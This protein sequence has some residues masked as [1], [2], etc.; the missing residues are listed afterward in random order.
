[1][2]RVIWSFLILSSPLLLAGA[3][4]FQA[5]VEQTQTYLSQGASQKAQ[6]QAQAAIRLAQS[7]EQTAMAWGLLGNSYL[8]QDAP[9]SAIEAYEKSDQIHASPQAAI[10]LA[11][12]YAKLAQSRAQTL[13]LI[14][15]SPQSQ[16]V[17]M[18]SRSSRALSDVVKKQKRRLQIQQ[19]AAKEQATRYT[20]RSLDAAT[21][22]NRIQAQLIALDQ[23]LII[24]RQA[25]QIFADL[26]SLPSSQFRLQQQIQ[27]S[28]YLPQQQISILE[29][30]I[31]QAKI[32]DAPNLQAQAQLNLAQAHRGRENHE[33]ALA[34]VNQAQLLAQ[35]EMDLNLLYQG[36]RLAAQLYRQT[37]QRDGSAG[38]RSEH[39]ALSSYQQA[40]QTLEQLEGKVAGEEIF[41]R[42]YLKLLLAS[43]HSQQL[44]RA[45][46]I[47]GNL[48]IA[49]L[50][51]YLG[52]PCP[53]LQPESPEQPKNQATVTTITFPKQTYLILQL[54]TGELRSYSVSVT[55]ATLERALKTYQ[56]QIYN[57][58]GTKHRQTG[59]Q[60]YEWLIAPI[61]PELSEHEI[62]T[63]IFNH[64]NFLRNI[65]MTALYDGENYLVEDYAISNTLGLDRIE[66]SSKTLTPLI[67]GIS[68]PRNGGSRLP[69]VK[70]ET[71]QIQI[72]MGG[73]QLLDN[74]FT[75]EQFKKQLQDKEY[76]ALHI[77]SHGIFGGTI[78]TSY[79]LTYNRPLPMTEFYRLLS[80]RPPLRLLVLSACETATGNRRS[81]L[82][83]AGIGVQT[84]AK[85]V[86]GTLW[87]LPDNK[88]T[89]ELMTG[90]YRRLD[91]V[92]QAEA[93]QEVMIRQIKDGTPVSNWASLILLKS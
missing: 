78:D 6:N 32:L 60:L 39:R 82:G 87:T 5:V 76:N 16:T 58:T 47:I 30:T 48:K 41:Y 88:N 9:N 11:Q 77:A 63:L 71:E 50:E 21:G 55:E 56:Q 44:E 62:D 31:Q 73:K 93:L 79:L 34:A 46:A 75:S 38:S 20:R 92:S 43:D 80:N 24:A 64:D 65:P 12:S 35:R 36:Q 15:E 83:M 52:F 61:E 27:L 14:E 49:Q 86:L 13:A 89:V 84:G 90:F 28:S 8:L 25:S 74:A 42:N 70:V 67:A 91:Q 81:V 66:P 72:L 51:N 53:N 3:T 37:R 69:N 59:K 57:L 68:K 40:S 2:L 18:S 17:A 85:N 29:T 26:Q 54:P 19:Q 23:G 22:N 4:S 1:M 33:A 10:G 7:P 45:L